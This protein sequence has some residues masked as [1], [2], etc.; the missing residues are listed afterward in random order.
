MVSFDPTR[1]DF[2]PYGLTCVRWSPSPMRRP[3]HHNEVE[4]NFLGSGWVIYLL[5]G[6]KVRL[7]AGRLNVFW[8]AIPHQILEYGAKTEYFVAT[9]PFAWFLQCRLPE[10]F[11]QALLR[12]EVHSEPT[13]D[14]RRADHDLFAQWEADLRQSRKESGDIVMLE[15]EARLMRLAAAFRLSRGKHANDM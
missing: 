2:A 10:N 7:E 3:D 13:A 11:V 4:L 1:P 12:G 14:R 9:I 5:G 15:I 8:A 6:R